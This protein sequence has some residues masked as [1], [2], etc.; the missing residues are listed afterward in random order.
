[1]GV[2]V[3]AVVVVVGVVLVVVSID[4]VVVF[5]RARQL[6]SEQHTCCSFWPLPLWRCLLYMF[7]VGMVLVVVLR[8]LLLLLYHSCDSLACLGAADKPLPARRF[9]RQRR[10]FV[11]SCRTMR[12]HVV[13]FSSC[14]HRATAPRSGLCSRRAR[15]NGPLPSS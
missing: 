2:V 4:A 6:A 11:C 1:M 10:Q 3:V 12:Q 9:L 8:L 14:M 15:L 5:P 13:A 7:V